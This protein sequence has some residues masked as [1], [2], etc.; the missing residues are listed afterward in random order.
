MFV[1][2]C[3]ICHYYFARIFFLK[4]HLKNKHMKN[5]I[6]N[7][8]D[9]NIKHNRNFGRHLNIHEKL[10]N[11]FCCKTCNKSFKIKYSY[12]RNSVS[13]KND[14]IIDVNLLCNYCGYLFTRSDNLKKHMKKCKKN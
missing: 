10:E 8:C 2:N 4:K 7:F 5:K 12:T 11:E 1:V 14:D 13:H 6:C 3:H 9:T